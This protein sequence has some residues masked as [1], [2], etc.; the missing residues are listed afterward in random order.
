MRIAGQFDG[1]YLH[2]DLWLWRLILYAHSVPHFGQSKVWDEDGWD[3][4][5]FCLLR[6]S[7]QL[8]ASLPQ[9]NSQLV[10]LTDEHQL[11]WSEASCCHD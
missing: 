1:Q 4:H 5:S 11:S 2:A 6:F 8:L 9:S 7:L 3:I 10:F